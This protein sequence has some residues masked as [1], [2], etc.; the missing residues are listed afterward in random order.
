MVLQEQ[1]SGVRGGWNLT[2]I[3][4]FRN[5]HEPW[6]HPPAARG[7]RS[8][9]PSRDTCWQ[10]VT[11]AS[12]RCAGR[13]VTT[14]G[15]PGSARYHHA[16]TPPPAYG[17]PDTGWGQDT[18]APHDPTNRV[19]RLLV[20]IG[21]CLPTPSSSLPDGRSASYAFSEASHATCARSHRAQRAHMRSESSVTLRRVARTTMAS[22]SHCFAAERRC[23]HLPTSASAELVG[24]LR[25]GH[26]CCGEEGGVNHSTRSGTL[27]GRG[28]RKGG[29][30]TPVSVD[31]KIVGQTK[32]RWCRA[33]T[34]EARMLHGTPRSR[35]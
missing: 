14:T 29:V 23:R 13:H 20:S 33:R 30:G 6:I 25:A 11:R 4:I 34:E 21:R 31:E 32:S 17:I 22:F 7:L 24:G 19:F 27:H 16:P 2:R 1:L 8:T 12:Q 18:R 10:R 26:G 3:R 5:T 28:W 15:R 9:L 35:C